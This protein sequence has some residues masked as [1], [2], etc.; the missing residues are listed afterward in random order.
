MVAM[1]LGSLADMAHSLGEHRVNV[2][3]R[4][5]VEDILP[6]ALELDEPCILQL[7]QLMG[8]SALRCADRL[9][10][11]GDATLA[12]HE[13]IQ[14]LYAGS[15]REHLEE[16]GQIVEHLLV[17]HGLI[18]VVGGAGT[19]LMSRGQKGSNIVGAMIIRR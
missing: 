18:E 8:Y 19:M 13:R 1:T 16:I 11:V 17:R 10:D 4:Q 12:I 5:R 14:Y 9:R 2:V 3:V 6:I 15:I 7:A